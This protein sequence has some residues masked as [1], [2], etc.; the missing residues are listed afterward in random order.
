MNTSTGFLLTLLLISS[1]TASAQEEPPRP[2]P[3]GIGSI[4]L[5]GT[6]DTF[7]A[8]AHRAIVKAA[9]G[10][11]HVFHLTGKTV[12]HG[13][14]TTGEDSAA[15]LE[16]GSHVV[17]QYVTE[18]GQKTAVEVDRV[19]EGGLTVLEGGV[20]DVNRG[21]KT[22]AIRLADGSAVT[23]RL[24]DRAAKDVGKDVKRADRVMVYYADEGGKHVAHYFKKITS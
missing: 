20:T 21:A 4:G 19:G 14:T 24:T 1:A 17:V 7:E 5:D 3:L 8:Q 10:L 13:A 16:V 18:G 12:V 9:D 2:T 15:G 6:I 11:R 23:L 22:L